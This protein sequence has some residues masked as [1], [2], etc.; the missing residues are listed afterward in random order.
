[1]KFCENLQKFRGPLRFAAGGRL[2][3]PGQGGGQIWGFGTDPGPHILF[4]AGSTADQST[5]LT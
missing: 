4:S 3:P 2:S 1:M 5:L